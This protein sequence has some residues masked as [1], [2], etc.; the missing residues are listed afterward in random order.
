MRRAVAI[1]VAMFCLAGNAGLADEV[2]TNTSGKPDWQTKETLAIKHL[3]PLKPTHDKKSPTG[4]Y[5]PNDLDDC[6]VELA[7]MLPVTA[8]Q[9]MK[10]CTEDDMI[11]YHSNFGMGLRNDWGLW[12]GSRLSS[13]FHGLGIYHPDDMSGIILV[14]FWRHLHGK[15]LKVQEQIH[16]YQEFWRGQKSAEE[17][18]GLRV[19]RASNEIAQRIIGLAVSGTEKASVR[20]PRRKDEGLRIRYL[21]EFRD[22]LFLTAKLV[23]SARDDFT[24][25]CFF[26]NKQDQQIHP[27]QLREIEHLQDGIVIDKT[28][29]L[30][31]QTQRTDVIIQVSNT[32]KKQIELPPGEGAINLCV[33]ANRLMAVRGH[34]VYELS[35]AGW[36]RI[37]KIVVCVPHT[38]TPP[39]VSERRIYFRDE[40]HDEDDKRLSWID[41]DHPDRLVTFDRDVGLVGPEG[42]RWENVWSFLPTKDGRL[43][44][45]TGS[46]V[47][48]A[49]LLVWNKENSYQ[50]CIMNGKLTFNGSLLGE[51]VFDKDPPSDSYEI[52][53]VSQDQHGDI[54]AV[55]PSGLFKL[56]DRRSLIKVVAFANTSQLIPVG[57]GHNYHW[58]WV[59][60]HVLE[61]SKDNYFIG[62]HWGGAYVLR[63]NDLG[64][65]E[66][67]SVDEKL[68]KPIAF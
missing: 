3:Y 31:G 34:D 18:E 24:I 23:G 36:Q 6:L 21:H 51:S 52:T 39:V 68:G 45:C 67:V 7:K 40:G 65:F 58:D 15:P 62:A 50:I 43:W 11:L 19:Q 55:G 30:H 33:G 25:Q 57:G 35:T 13:Y 56:R 32:G 42:P 48:N 63:R 53:G 38:A 14:S 64:Q 22:G 49:S 26:W 54:I 44:I 66:L 8:L 12:K 46:S 16:H 61:T 2:A 59:P 20:L 37:V 29:Y 5:V 1:V 17:V 41:L 28:A 9:D 4:F 47:G 27:V 60:T 10:S